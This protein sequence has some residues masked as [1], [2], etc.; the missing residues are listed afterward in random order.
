MEGRT[1]AVWAS[2]HVC[3]RSGQLQLRVLSVG[4]LWV[5][6]F[7][8]EHWTLPPGAHAFQGPPCVA[9]LG[10]QPWEGAGLKAA[11]P[12]CVPDLP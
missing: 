8:L 2:N 4:G 7:W 5:W 9:G 12:C 3:T 10:A 1:G 6:W 11:Q